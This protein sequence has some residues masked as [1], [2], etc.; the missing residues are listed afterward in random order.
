MYPALSRCASMTYIPPG[1]GAYDLWGMDFG[2]TLDTTSGVITRVEPRGDL[3]ELH[4]RLVHCVRAA[5]MGRTLLS[6]NIVPEVTV[7]FRNRYLR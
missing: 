3:R 1:E 5:M 6:E 2:F 7:F 4:P